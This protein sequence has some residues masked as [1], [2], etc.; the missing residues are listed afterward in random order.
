MGT[1]FSTN[2]KAVAQANL[3]LLGSTIESLVV[4]FDQE[5]FKE[6]FSSGSISLVSSKTRSQIS[7][8]TSHREAH[9]LFQSK[10]LNLF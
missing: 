9:T 4:K 7:S 5:K 1:I 10:W 6:L 3:K 2:E 8:E